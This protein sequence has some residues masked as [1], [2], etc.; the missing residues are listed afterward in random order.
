MISINVKQEPFY[1]PSS[2]EGDLRFEQLHYLAHLHGNQSPFPENECRLIESAHFKDQR[3]WVGLYFGVIVATLL[4]TGGSFAALQ[5]LDKHYSAKTNLWIALSITVTVVALTSIMGYLFTG[6]FTHASGGA[7]TKAERGNTRIEYTYQQ[8]AKKLLTLH[9]EQ[10]PRTDACKQ[11][12]LENLSA[13]MVKALDDKPHA[14]FILQNLNFVVRYIRGNVSLNS[15]P[16]ED[17]KKMICNR[18]NLQTNSD[19]KDFVLS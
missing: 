17:L 18:I 9:L 15:C 1:L 3:A 11:I 12:D 2:S 13:K 8:L 4:S 10:D 5:S 16:D 14:D 19:P 6:F 7:S